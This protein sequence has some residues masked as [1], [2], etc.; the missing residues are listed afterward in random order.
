MSKT[1]PSFFQQ[2]NVENG[3]AAGGLTS[4]DAADIT[5]DLMVATSRIATV[6]AGGG[7]STDAVNFT[8]ANRTDV[9]CAIALT[10]AGTVT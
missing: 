8:T 10:G 7:A 3:G 6:T 4:I 5:S 1:A 9:D 2:L